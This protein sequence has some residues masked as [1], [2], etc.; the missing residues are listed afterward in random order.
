[1]LILDEPT[2]ALDVR[3]ELAVRGSLEQIKSEVVLFLVAHRLS[4]LS[5]SI[6]SW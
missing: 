3:S 4:P 6:G 2:S 1:V 5:I